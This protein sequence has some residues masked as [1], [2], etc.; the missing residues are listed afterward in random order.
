V[1]RQREGGVVTARL[2]ELL[3]TVTRDRARA[4][5]DLAGARAEADQLR[6]ERDAARL[7]AMTARE[8]LAY[9]GLTPVEGAA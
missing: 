1:P 3:T 6:A 7:E 2:E 4:Y 5:A 8:L 9:H